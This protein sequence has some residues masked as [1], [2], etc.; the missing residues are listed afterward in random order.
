MTADFGRKP[1]RKVFQDLGVP[2]WQRDVVPLVYLD[3]ELIAIGHFWLAPH[4][5]PDS[6][7]NG[8]VFVSRRAHVSIEN[9]RAL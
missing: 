3:G 4:L 6:D 2:R 7:S 8:L 5:A 1:L 9:K